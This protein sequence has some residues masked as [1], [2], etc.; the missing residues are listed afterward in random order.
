M[1]AFRKRL[2]ALALA[3]ACTAPMLVSGQ[4][5][6]SD[7]SDVEATIEKWVSDFNK[8]DMRSFVA[9]CARH[10]AVVDG[11]PPYAWQT[12][13]DWMRDYD[14]NNRAIGATPG[15]LSIGKAIYTEVTAGR[16][17]FIYPA[18]FADTQ[19]GKPVVYKG[20]WTMTLQKTQAGWVFTGSAS[21]WGVNDL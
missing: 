18:T 13:A 9:A 19:K 17:Y 20:T 12:C 7:V 6:A 15:S 16:A 3:I 8:G 2:P 14:V 4:A 21:A 5:V 1:R 11:F 10:A